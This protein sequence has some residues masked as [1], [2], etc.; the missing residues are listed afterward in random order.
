MIIVIDNNYTA[1]SC[2]STDMDLKGAELGEWFGVTR[3]DDP[4]CFFAEPADLA[5]VLAE[6]NV[7]LP[8]CTRPCHDVS[9]QSEQ[10][11]TTIGTPPDGEVIVFGAGRF[12]IQPNGT[13]GYILINP[14][15]DVSRRT[16]D[17]KVNVV[18][19]CPDV[20]RALRVGVLATMHNDPRTFDY[21]QFEQTYRTLTASL[22]A[23]VR[24]CPA[25]EAPASKVEEPYR[26]RRVIRSTKQKSNKASGSS[27]P[28]TEPSRHSSLTDAAIKQ[29]REALQQLITDTWTGT[30]PEAAELAR[31]MRD[32]G[33]NVTAATIMKDLCL[34]VAGK[35]LR[36][37]GAAAH[38]PPH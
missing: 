22:W 36:P 25:A 15:A 4:R 3:E 23:D 14:S 8:E 1:R 33:F 27:L 21:A 6:Q 24:R 12:V 38:Q 37:C 17:G 2:G 10:L 16:V 11:A 30:I 20:A 7:L 9:A 18:G 29:R 19:E 32:Q 34:I 26:R 31:A 28:S 5:R 35:L 13:T